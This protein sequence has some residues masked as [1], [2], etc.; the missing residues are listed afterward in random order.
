MSEQAAV[1]INSLLKRQ[2]EIDEIFEKY[3][4]VSVIDWLEKLDNRMTETEKKV[5]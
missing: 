3:G 5:K 2:K 4:V 1:D